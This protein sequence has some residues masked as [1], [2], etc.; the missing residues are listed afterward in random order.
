MLQEQIID[1]TDNHKGVDDRIIQVYAK[2][3]KLW[4]EPRVSTQIPGQ[5]LLVCTSGM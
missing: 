3:I 2:S 1:G 5:R 4:M